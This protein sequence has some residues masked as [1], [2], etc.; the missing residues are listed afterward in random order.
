[1][2]NNEKV[3]KGIGV[4]GKYNNYGGTY[5]YELDNNSTYTLV[6]S[7]ITYCIKC[8]SELGEDSVGSRFCDNECR[9]EFYSEI[10]HDISGIEY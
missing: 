2:S 10:R 9:R 8:G 1:M 3:N 5:T 7:E 4:G 6:D